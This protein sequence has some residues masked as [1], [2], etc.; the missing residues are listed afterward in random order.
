MPPA[1]TEPSTPTHAAQTV[2]QLPKTTLIP[3]NPFISFSG[4]PE[5]K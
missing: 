5:M 1:G 3:L 4:S 2:T